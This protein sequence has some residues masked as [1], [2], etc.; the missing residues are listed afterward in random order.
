MSQHRIFNVTM[1]IAC[2]AAWMVIAGMLDK[3]L[4]EGDARHN[5]DTQVEKRR[6]D[7]AMQA[8]GNASARWIDATTMVCQKHTGRGKSVITAGVVL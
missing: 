8:C 3:Q 1:A 5:N 6:N 2:I 4:M 7:A